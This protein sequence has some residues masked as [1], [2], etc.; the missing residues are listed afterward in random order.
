[1]KFIK[2]LLT[3][4]K[5]EKGNIIKLFISPLIG[6]LFVGYVFSHPFVE[7]VPFAVVDNDNSSLSRNIVYQLKNNPTLSIDLYADSE[8]ELEEAIDNKTVAGG[9]VIPKDFGKDVG[10]SKSP[11]ALILVDGT[12][13]LIGGNALG[14]C[15]TVLGTMNAG[16]QLN[17]FQGRGLL[18]NTAKQ[19]ISNF[20]YVD[21]L[22]YEPQSS[23]LRNLIYTIIPFMIQMFFLT[24]FLVP[25]LIEKKKE[26]SSIK[27]WS[28]DGA[29]SIINTALRIFINS[30]VLIVASFA[31]LCIV[32]KLYDIPLRG[33][34]LIY[35]V[36]M[37]VFLINLTAIGLVLATIFNKSVYFILFY[38]LIYL[39]IMLTC[40]VTYPL[41]MMPDGFANAV[42]SIWP[43]I[44]SALPLKYLNLKGL[45]WDLMLPYIKEGLRY[46]LVWMPIGIT[47]YFSKIAFK[48]YRNQKVRLIKD[49]QE[50][51]ME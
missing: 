47:L 25:L 50:V 33:N 7:N 16:A 9:I 38:Q 21:R 51:V 44:H 24:S 13:M 31:S 49:G 14:A 3:A 8:L 39:A 20:S 22:L 41:Y 27:V 30:T 48:K 26:L 40:G 45:G 46:T 18:P 36:L 10:L 42:G 4:L 15:S 32:K 11:K 34:I 28:K 43:F 17:V 5:Q 6:T 35:G 29:K 37:Y 1:M 12:N 2:M 19:T 23:Y